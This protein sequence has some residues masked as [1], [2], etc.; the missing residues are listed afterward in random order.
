M[1][2]LTHL[3]HLRIR[4]RT[5]F[6]LLGIINTKKLIFRFKMRWQ[7]TRFVVVLS[8]YHD[9]PFPKR[10]S[11]Y[12]IILFVKCY[13]LG[14]YYPG[15]PEPSAF[16]TAWFVLSFLKN[17]IRIGFMLYA[18]SQLSI[19]ANNEWKNEF[20]KLPTKQE[21]TSFLSDILQPWMCWH[22]SISGMVW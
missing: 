9:R 10:I 18:T 4:L 14:G 6:S 16:S 2:T 3:R 21:I 20:L 5:S 17:G 7:K 11:A 8:Q 1:R 22:R 19:F 15:I 12:G 13:C